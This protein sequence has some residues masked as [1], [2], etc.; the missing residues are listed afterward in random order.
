MRLFSFRLM[1]C[2][3]TFGGLFCGLC[4]YV[5]DLASCPNVDSLLKVRFY[6]SNLTVF[7][8]S[9]KWSYDDFMDLEIRD[10]R[11]VDKILL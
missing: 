9:V 2:K 6:V 7:S 10:V 1:F 4:E 3:L 11:F 8:L 5:M